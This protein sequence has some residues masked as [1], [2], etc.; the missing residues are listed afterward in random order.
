MSQ[1]NISPNSVR[2]KCELKC[3]YNFKYQAV[4]VTARND[5]A[6]ISLTPDQES[7]PSVLYNKSKYTV[8]ASYLFSP[9]LHLYN[10]KLADAEF[11]TVHVPIEGGGFLYVCIPIKISDNSTPA[12]T[13]ITD[14]INS[15]ATSANSIGEK[16]SIGNFNLAKIF[17][18]K[19]FINYLYHQSFEMIVFPLTE[20]I[21]IKSSTIDKLK[22]IITLIPEPFKGDVD[23]FYNSVGPN[24]TTTLGDGIYISCNPTGVSTETTEVAY[25]KDEVEAI[26]LDNLSE[27]E[28]VKMLL[29]ALLLGAV[30][31]V[32]FFIFNNFFNFIDGSKKV[33]LGS[34]KAPKV[35]NGPNAP[36]V[37][38]GPNA[39][40]VK[41]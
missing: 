29:L 39:P 21:P 30:F 32:I 34:P 1:I 11:I 13:M 35:S 40:K 36:K 28:Y 7:V 27:N 22:K 18:N 6:Y 16:V 2:G 37:S 23:L 15:V 20:A 14:V 8:I 10:G 25:F 12:T 3:A 5:G 41:S 38:N 17:P 4:N 24:S 9:S 31:L 26:T 33:S 19:P